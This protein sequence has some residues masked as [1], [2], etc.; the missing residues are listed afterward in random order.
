MPIVKCIVCSKK[1]YKRPFVLKKNKKG[2]FCS[3]ECNKKYLH[4]LRPEANR[5]CKYCGKSFRTNP[6]YIKRRKNAGIY[7]SRQCFYNYL[8]FNPTINIGTDGYYHIGTTRLHRLIMEQYLGKKL[9][10]KEH[11]HHINGNKLDNRIE[12][13]EVLIDSKHHS[14]HKRM[15]TGQIIYC[16]KCG[17][18]KYYPI[19]TLTN[20][21][22]AN[23]YRCFSCRKIYGFASYKRHH[24]K[25][26]NYLDDNS[27]K[28]V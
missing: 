3:I 2:P 22:I 23:I 15:K 27:S 19:S 10:T 20:G 8:Q 11:V 21:S 5:I 4:S 6:A 13:L 17:K 14:K 18:G 25:D 1:H 28:Q 9:T 7:C 12:N 16:D 24:K 26:E